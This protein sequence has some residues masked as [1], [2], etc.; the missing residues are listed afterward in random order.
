MNKLL[1]VVFLYAI[2]GWMELQAREPVTLHSP[3]PG[4]LRLNYDA[5]IAS[6]I[7]VTGRIDAT[8]MSVLKRIT[9]HR[10]RELDLSE[11]TIEAYK[12]YNGTLC[13]LLPDWII[14]NP[15]EYLY[16]ANTLPV[17][18]YTEEISGLTGYYLSGS[19]TLQRLV[20]PST[21]ENIE[22]DAFWG[23]SMLVELVVPENSP[24]LRSVDNVIY[25]ADM[26][27]LVAIA[28]CYAGDLEIPSS[29]EKIDSCALKGARIACLKFNSTVPPDMPGSAIIDAAYVQAG[30]PVEY[31]KLFPNIDCVSSIDEVVVLNNSQGELL[32]NI[33][34]QGVETDEVRR[35][36]VTGEVSIDDLDELFALPNLHYADLSGA[37]TSGKVKIPAGTLCDVKFPSGSYS[38]EIGDNYLHGSLVLPEGVSYLSCLNTYYTSAVFPSTLSGIS[39]KRGIIESADFSACKDMRTLRAFSECS[40]L[41]TLLLPPNL[42]ELYD[43]NASLASV[44]F[45][46]SLTN[47]EDCSG[48]EVETLRLPSS[49]ERI[50]YFNV[51]YY[52]KEIDASKCSKLTYMDGAFDYCPLLTHV[53]LSMCPVLTLSG[54]HGV[55]MV[56]ADGSIE[57]VGGGAGIGGTRL[58]RMRFSGL[59]QIKLPSSA[60]KV[61]VSFRCPNLKELDLEHCYALKGLE[62]DDCYRLSKLS[63]PPSL[64][65]IGLEGCTGLKE[66]RA[67]SVM[68]PKFYDA[69]DTILLSNVVLHVPLRSGAKYRA[70]LWRECKEIVE[71]GYSV[72]IS[73]DDAFLIDG[74]GLYGKGENATLSFTPTPVNEF[75]NYEINEWLINDTLSLTGNV[76]TFQPTG[77]STVVA[78][79]VKGEFDYDKCDIVLELEAQKD[80]SCILDFSNFVKIYDSN[81][82]EY[83]DKDKSIALPLKKGVQQFVIVGDVGTLDFNAKFI[84]SN[85]LKL[86]LLKVIDKESLHELNVRWTKCDELDLSGC[87]NLTKLVANKCGLVK[88]NVSGCT[89]LAEMNLM[90]NALTEINLTGCSGL[91]KINVRD[92]DLVEL[93]LSDSPKL[94]DFFLYPNEKLEK[95]N[96]SGCALVPD[97]TVNS[98]VLKEIDL[99]GCVSLKMLSL[100]NNLLTSLVLTEGCDKLEYVYVANNNL[101]KLRLPGCSSLVYL[102]MSGNPNLEV[103]DLSGCSSLPDLFLADGVVREVNLA[104]CSGLQVCSVSYNNLKSIDLSDCAELTT[105]NVEHNELEELDLSRN[106][107]INTLYMSHNPLKRLNLSGLAE[108]TRVNIGARF[109]L[110]KLETAD[111]SGTG[112]AEI[113]ISGCA[114]KE[115]DLSNCLKLKNVNVSGNSI[116][117]LWLDGC[118]GVTQL[119]ADNNSMSELDLSDCVNLE[120]LQC[121]NNWLRELVLAPGTPTQRAM[122]SSNPSAFSIM[123]PTLYEVLYAPS[124]MMYKVDEYTVDQLGY[125]DLSAELHPQGCSEPTV[126]DFSRSERLPEG[127]GNGM[128]DLAYNGVYVFVMTNAD[129]P[130]LRY[131]G[132][133][134]YHSGT[135][136][137]VISSALLDGVKVMVSG[138]EVVV[139][140][141]ADG[142]A[143]ALVSLNGRVLARTVADGTEAARIAVPDEGGDV[144]L[145]TFDNGMERGALKIVAK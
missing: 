138:D 77:N 96:M 35:V 63:L 13:M 56:L 23:A 74:A 108:L 33:A 49:L 129:Y 57:S 140:G 50:R 135:D 81:G 98:G 114:L 85:K 71:E 137:S 94:V 15:K 73:A 124:N 7:K 42:E 143:V 43:V 122:L 139:E 131:T 82:K 112:I 55:D 141:L 111:L 24:H 25:T 16:K 31:K 132:A 11:V 121:R 92:N 37:T 10:T 34:K 22:P 80:T 59:E 75:Q 106:T 62:I 110:S 91:T 18:S 145:L 103:L 134:T 4:E 104:G 97:L 9:M 6:E 117:H 60:R 118:T 99:S 116:E 79:V 32:E 87:S 44:E 83:S 61:S 127:D 93:D 123:T 47:I 17:H 21:L 76:V 89:K 66:I 115:L 133:F 2:V 58:P 125:I 64:T 90:N 30:N 8:D 51:M 1:L 142:V 5:L 48:W 67:S 46:E 45:P 101:T 29:V 119:L 126:I 109:G 65:T 107:K 130:E 40:N 53:D 41:T 19:T 105:L 78:E 12:G 136:P 95:L 100:D 72:A 26:K 68:P 69:S 27:R 14:G 113:N 102:S 70:N 38:L 28:P 52:L 86:K 144:Y 54:F 39:Y 128:Y 84:C 36:R 3:A 88:L 20:L 120:Q